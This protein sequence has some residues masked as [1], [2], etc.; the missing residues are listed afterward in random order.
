[1][2]LRD[3]MHAAEGA[4]EPH[5]ETL[6]M[7][8]NVNRDRKKRARPFSGGEFNPFADPSKR[9]PSTFGIPIGTGNITLLRAL[10]PKKAGAGPQKCD[11][12]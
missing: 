4:W 3:L 8:A 6:A 1:M 11:L 5:A 12:K 9:K 10:V 2:S 7:M